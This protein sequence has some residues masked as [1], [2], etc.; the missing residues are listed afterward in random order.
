MA[1]YFAV[2]ALLWRILCCL[3]GCVTLEKIKRGPGTCIP[4]PRCYEKRQ[5]TSFISTSPLLILVY[6]LARDDCLSR[7]AESARLFPWIS[8][9]PILLD[10]RSTFKFVPVSVRLLCRCIPFS[11]HPKVHT[12][13]YTHNSTRDMYCRAIAHLLNEIKVN[14]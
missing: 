9:L 12:R 1:G 10:C 6:I 8:V 13:T 5:V 7:N 11:S 4:D 2:F 3:G 14:K